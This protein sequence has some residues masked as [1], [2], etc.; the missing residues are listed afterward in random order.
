MKVNY[1]IDLIRV[2]HSHALYIEI[3]NIEEREKLN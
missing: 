1:C 3:Q 2:I